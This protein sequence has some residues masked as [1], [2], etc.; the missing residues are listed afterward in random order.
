MSRHQQVSSSFA[1]SLPR[2]LH[3]LNNLLH[4]ARIAQR[5]DIS[6][7]ILLARQN[8][9]QNATHDLAGA[10]LGQIRDA[11]HRL[12]SREWSDR[13]ADLH[14]ERLAQLVVLLVAVLD[15]HES[16]NSLA[17]ELIVDTDDSRLAD[18]MVLDERGFDFGGRQAVAR[19][20]D[21]VVDAAADPVVALGV[22]GGAV[23]G[24]VVA[25]VDVE[26]GVHVALVGAPDGAAHGGPGLLEGEDA[27]D[28]VAVDFFA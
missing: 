19:D 20:V 11:E 21:D 6:K 4:N 10:R 8:L 15:R 3:R 7:L 22:A 16:V 13:L 9:S 25:L 5:A 24:E 18:G 1:S 28:V 17:S 14:D 26:V 27:F 23:A 12:G 2:R